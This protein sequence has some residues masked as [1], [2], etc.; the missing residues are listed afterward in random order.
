M[1]DAA[2]R[3]VEQDRV[4]RRV[5]PDPADELDHT[6]GTG[7]GEGHARGGPGRDDG[8]VGQPADRATR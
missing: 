3:E 4:G 8:R 5:V 1:T 2:P 7:R 6:P